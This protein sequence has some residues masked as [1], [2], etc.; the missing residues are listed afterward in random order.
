MLTASKVVQQALNGNYIGLPYS[1]LDCQGLIKR[2]LADAGE[3]HSARGSNYMW[4]YWLSAWGTKSGMLIEP[5][6]LVFTIKNDGGEVARGYR[7][8][9][10]N[11]AHVGLVVAE[12]KVIHSSKGGVQWAAVDDKR[13]THAGKMS[14]VDYSTQVESGFDDKALIE[15]LKDIINK[16]EERTNDH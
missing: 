13:W 10:G 14:F 11:A 2:I 12:N 9:R 6:M 5:G 1:R 7:D 4:R 16:L 3:A 15:S 8:N